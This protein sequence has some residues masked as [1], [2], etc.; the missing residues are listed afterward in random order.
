MKIKKLDIN[1]IHC[2]ICRIKMVRKDN[3]VECPECGFTSPILLVV[4]KAGYEEHNE[5]L[6]K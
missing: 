5:Q 3:E 1:K 4:H 2:P 6:Y